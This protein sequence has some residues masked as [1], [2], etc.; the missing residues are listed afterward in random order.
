M[1]ELEEVLQTGSEEKGSVEEEN[2]FEG[3][4]FL[5]AE[6]N[7]LNAEIL[8]ELLKLKGAKVDVAE[9]GE[10]VVA[11]FKEKPKGYY[12]MILMDIQMPNM[13]GYEAARAIRAM[14]DEG[15]E[16]VKTIPIIA[17]SANAFRDDI[18]KTGLSGMDAHLAKPIDRKLFESTVRALKLREHEKL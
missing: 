1:K 14:A 15:R 7:E 10:K 4:R 13:D 11:A 17:M 18:E 6:D 9:D 5:A 2:V 8:V 3:M 16:D 12:D